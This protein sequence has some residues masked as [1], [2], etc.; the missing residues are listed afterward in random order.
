MKK[1]KKNRENLKEIKLYRG[2]GPV[3]RFNETPKGDVITWFDDSE[4]WSLEGNYVRK[5]DVV[6]GDMTYH[7]SSVFLNEDV[8]TSTPTDKLLSHIDMQMKKEKSS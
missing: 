7:I 4:F 6:I 1:A 5:R 3:I 2:H 8:R